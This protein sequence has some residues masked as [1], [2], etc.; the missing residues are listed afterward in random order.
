MAR[1]A[2]MDL[3]EYTER[4]KFLT[5]R[6]PHP[7]MNAYAERRVRTV[8]AEYRSVPRGAHHSETGRPG[9]RQIATLAP[10]RDRQPAQPSPNP[11]P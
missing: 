7:R 6:I 4:F 1:N 5:S 8:R 9:R 10:Y 3:A 11:D 2:L